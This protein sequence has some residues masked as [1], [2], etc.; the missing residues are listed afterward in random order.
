MHPLALRKN[1]FGCHKRCP[2]RRVI[3]ERF[4]AGDMPCATA[5]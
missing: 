3:G 1:L 2:W 4:S 5:H